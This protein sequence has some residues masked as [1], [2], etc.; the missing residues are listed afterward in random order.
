VVRDAIVGD[1]GSRTFTAQ[2]FRA[3]VPIPSR[4]RPSR[5]LRWG[6]QTFLGRPEV[7]EGFFATADMSLATGKRWLCGLRG[8]IQAKSGLETPPGVSVETFLEATAAAVA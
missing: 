1:T 7:L 8:G 6:F 3:S 5:C 2:L 4:I